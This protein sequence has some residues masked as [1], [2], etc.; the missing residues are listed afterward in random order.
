M[1]II[2][3]NTFE[4]NGGAA[5]ACNRLA[6]A[7]R[8]NGVEAK[9]L[10]RDKQTDNDHTI[11]VNKSILTKTLNKLRFREER[12]L[13]WIRNRFSK[14]N[15]FAVSIAN[16]GIDI[17]KEKEIKEADII[18]IHWINQGFLSLQDLKKLTALEKPIVWTMHDQWPYTGICHYTS[19]CDRFAEVC[20]CCPKLK[21]PGKN[22]LSYK[23]FKRKMKLYQ[24][25]TFTFAGC[26]RWIA[27]EAKKS[28]LCRKAKIVSIP[29]PIDTAIYDKQDKMEARKLFDLP[30]SEKLILFG[31]CKVT[32]KRKGFDYMKKACDLLYKKNIL[33][34][35]DVAI[36]VFGGKTN[37]IESLLPYNIHPVGYVNDVKTMANLYS[38]VDLFLMPSLEDNLPNTIMEAMSCGVPCVGF[39]TGGIPEMIDHKKNGYIAGYKNAEDLVEGIRWILKEADYHEISINARRKV[40]EEYGENKVAK[41]YIDLYNRLLH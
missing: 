39:D 37:E 19:G 38:A 22:D 30:L 8:K 20:S 36:V 29:N 26:S 10:V 17:S 25:N 4:L 27:N 31:A 16:T 40:I 13:I 5:I 12:L 28:G 18:H 6:I 23:I 33:E 3:L 21:N 2:L 14:N 15:L 35:K 9:V 11:S 1:K 41:Q 34:K 32:D 7:L 24:S